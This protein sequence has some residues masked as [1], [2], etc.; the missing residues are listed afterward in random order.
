MIDVPTEAR[1]GTVSNASVDVLFANTSVTGALDVDTVAGELT[2]RTVGVG[3]GTLEIVV[4]TGTVIALEFIATAG[5]AIGAD[6]S[7]AQ[8]VFDAMICTLVDILTEGSIDVSLSSNLLDVD[9]DL[10]GAVIAAKE[11]TVTASLEE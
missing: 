9:I 5:A 7:I 10:L 4:V 3:I 2:D 1:A 6:V 8:M 11:C